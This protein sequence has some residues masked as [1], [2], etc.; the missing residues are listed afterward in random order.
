MPDHRGEAVAGL[1]LVAIA[2]LSA[3]GNFVAV[4]P[5]GDQANTAHELTD[6]DP[7]F[8]LGIAALAVVAIL[9]V[10][11]SFALFKVFSPAGTSLARVASGLRIAYAVGFAVAIWQLLPVTRY[12]GGELSSGTTA[13]RQAG[14]EAGIDRFNDVWHVAL[15][16]FG[17]H[18]A[19]LAVLARKA[20]L[21]QVLAVLLGIAGGGY[22][23]DS[24]LNALTR[25]APEVSAFTF[26][27][28]F[29]LALW[30]VARGLRRRPQRQR[31]A[32]HQPALT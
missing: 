31:G 26:V 30:L 25:T 27:G 15:T 14:V 7:L 29:T 12:L 22:V 24:A 2:A 8:R 11:V 1:T 18:L 21:P 23:F 4:Q 3:V 28:E 16:L 32:T 19:A 5:L 13:A 9:D 6:A 20:G 10:V 17:L